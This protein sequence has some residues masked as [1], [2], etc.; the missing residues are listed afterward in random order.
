MCVG[1]G[2]DCA[3]VCS[4][5]CC[6]GS[7]PVRGTEG[8]GVEEGDGQCELE[9]DPGADPHLQQCSTAGAER[10]ATAEPTARMC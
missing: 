3:G 5:A 8:G 6:V 9:S 2:T 1:P 7:V 10:D 4:S